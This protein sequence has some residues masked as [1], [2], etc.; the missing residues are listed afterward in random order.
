MAW[1]PPNRAELRARV[2]FEKRIG[3]SNVGGVVRSTWETF[4][5]DRRVRLLPLRGGEDVQADRAAGVSIWVLDVPADA[6]LRGVTT[7]MRAVDCRDETRTWNIKSVLDLLG[8]DL[9]RT[10]TLEFGGA[11][12]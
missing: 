11:D 2:R 7:D 10:M 8:T 6:V 12:G 1:T 4:C 9:W 5:P 3:R